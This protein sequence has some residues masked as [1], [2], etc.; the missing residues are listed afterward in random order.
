M[1]G[2]ARGVL[3]TVTTM[4]CSQVVGVFMGTLSINPSLQY[5]SSPSLTPSCQWSGTM[6]G[7]WSA[8]GFARGSTW[9]WRGGLLFMWGRGCL[10][11]VLKDDDLYLSNRY[12]F[13]RETL[14]GVAAHGSV[15]GVEGGFVW[16]GQ[17]QGGS[18]GWTTPLLLHLAL[19]KAATTVSSSIPTFG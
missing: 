5:L 16:V 18:P 11:Q 12:C 9:S 15:G 14:S 19:P 6:A 17:E 4:R 10:S 3:V 13:R 7:T 1:V 2:L 8:T